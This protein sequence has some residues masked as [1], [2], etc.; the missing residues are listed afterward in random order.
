[1]YLEQPYSLAAPF[2]RDL[3]RFALM[4]CA[5]CQQDVPAVA[6]SAREPLIC[7][8]CQHEL[9]RQT[10]AIPSDAGV[11]LDSFD[12]GANA[13]AATVPLA[14]IADAAAVALAHIALRSADAI[15]S[16]PRGG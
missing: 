10:S 15:D 14:R 1:M 7:P 9:A 2:C 13:R 8:R 6:R 4:W 5:D 16:S 12:Q 11:A 3:A